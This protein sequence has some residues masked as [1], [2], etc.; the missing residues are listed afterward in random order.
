[1][2]ENLVHEDGIGDV[3]RMKQ[4]HLKQFR[5]QVRL[6]RLVILQSLE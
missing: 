3:R 2:R 5:L 1:M 4:V 6:L